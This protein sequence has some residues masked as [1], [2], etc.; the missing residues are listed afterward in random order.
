MMLIVDRRRGRCYLRVPRRGD[1]AAAAGDRVRP[2]TMLVGEAMSRST[3]CC[4]VGRGWTETATADATCRLCPL[5]GT[6]QYQ[7]YYL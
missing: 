3:C 4:T 7:Y 1:V 2:C 6:R 5:N